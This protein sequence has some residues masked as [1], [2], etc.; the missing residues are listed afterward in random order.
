MSTVQVDC[1]VRDA[2]FVAGAESFAGV[3]IR[4]VAGRAT[5]SD[6]DTQAMAF[7]EHNAGGPEIDFERIDLAWFEQLFA[8]ERLAETGAQD[9]LADVERASIG[10]DIAQ[11]GKEI[12]VWRVARRPQF[13]THFANDFQRF[14]E[15]LAGKDKH[16]RAGFY[17]ALVHRAGGQSQ[18]GTADSRHGVFRIVSVG[19]RGRV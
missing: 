6:V 13:H 1:V 8:G 16:V 10:I 9:S 11:L 5:G 14:G 19:Y 4:I 7:V 3:R 12:S 15:R 18:L 2:G 17:R